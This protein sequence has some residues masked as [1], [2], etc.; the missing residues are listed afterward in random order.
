MWVPGINS[1]QQAWCQ[2]PLPTK[3]SHQP[4]SDSQYEYKKLGVAV[5]AYNLRALKKHRKILEPS[6]QLL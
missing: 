1:G 6:G 5:P 2:A 4:D 3:P